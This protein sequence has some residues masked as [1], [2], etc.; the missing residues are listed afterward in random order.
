MC[1]AYNHNHPKIK[2]RGATTTSVTTTSRHS[3]RRVAKTGLAFAFVL[4]PLGPGLPYVVTSSRDEG[5][6][7]APRGVCFDAGVPRRKPRNMPSF[8]RAYLSRMNSKHRLGLK[9][10]A[11][12]ESELE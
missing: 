5:L 3:P 10:S 6:L 1:A 9:R 4:L 11:E 8:P 2:T 7:A 12:L